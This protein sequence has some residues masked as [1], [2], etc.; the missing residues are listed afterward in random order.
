MRIVQL[1]E[2]VRTSQL[3]HANRLVYGR[4]YAPERQYLACCGMSTW[5]CSMRHLLR[6]ACCEDEVCIR[7]ATAWSLEEL[8]A[9]RQLAFSDLTEEFVRAVWG[10]S[11]RYELVHMLADSTMSTIQ[12][13]GNVV[14][15]DVHCIVHTSRSGATSQHLF[16]L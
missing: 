3:M 1:A 7:Y 6:A 12:V 8:E 2:C 4:P 9:L 5:L 16:M 13:L 11:A 10:G 14:V 15:Q